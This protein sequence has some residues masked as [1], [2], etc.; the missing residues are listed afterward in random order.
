MKQRFIL[1]ASEVQK[2]EKKPESYKDISQT[3]YKP[4]CQTFGKMLEEKCG[5]TMLHWRFGER[6]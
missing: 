2:L 6:A 5:K 1:N 3:F 4:N